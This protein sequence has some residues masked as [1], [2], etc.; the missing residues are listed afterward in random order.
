MQ[1]ERHDG[2]KE[3]K[4]YDSNKEMMKDAN[5]V[6]RDPSVKKIILYPK[7]TIPKRRR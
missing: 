5:K 6:I 3:I 2:T 4:F 1:T 7:K